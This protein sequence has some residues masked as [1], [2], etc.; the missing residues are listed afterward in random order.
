VFDYEDGHYYADG[1][2][3]TNPWT[4]DVGGGAPPPPPPPPPPGGGGG[5]DEPTITETTNTPSQ[6][7]Q[8]AETKGFQAEINWD[9]AIGTISF[10]PYYSEQKS[11]DV[12]DDVEV[13]F[14]GIE[15]PSYTTQHGENHT[16][17][18]GADLR[19]AS[20]EDFLFK[21]IV[22]YTYYESER[23]DFRDDENYD[24]NDRSNFTTQENKAVYANITYPFTDRFRGTAGYRRSWDKVGNVEKPPKVG[25]G[26]SGQEYD[27]PDY[28]V[29]IE[30]DLAEDS[31]LYASY[32]TSYRVNAMAISQ[33]DE[34]VPPEELKSYTVGAKNR[35]FDNR[36]QVNASAYFYDYQNKGFRGSSDGRFARG[37]VIR[38]SD[39]E[40]DELPGTD[41]NNDGDYVDTNLNP[42]DPGLQPGE[43]SDLVGMELTDPW[44]QQSGAFENIG[45]DVSVDWLISSKDRLNLSLTYMDATWEDATVNFYWSW[46]WD[47]EGKSYNGKRAAYSSKWAWHASYEHQF[48]LGGFGTLVPQVNV[49]YKSDYYLGF[50]D[51]WYPYNYQ[52]PYYILN[53]S[54][55]FNHISGRWSINAYVKNATEYAAKSFWQAPAGTPRLGI[56]DPRTY[57]AIVNVNF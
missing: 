31:M 4:R 38:E 54:L 56:T 35:F 6:M 13:Y 45:L 53:G 33:G 43:S 49:Q 32:A 30:Y 12:R 36:L 41:F 40:H 34:S 28:K 2:P 21:W 7:N 18:K 5:S 57:G 37:A 55:T 27:K 14:A 16:E 50:E 20:P 42:G 22:G 39:Y 19:I 9:T 23:A 46:I 47:D 15:E 8:T 44:I 17:Q 51:S 52:E 48:D 29:G 26:V 10:V 24:S 11:V 3:V 25:D 1:S